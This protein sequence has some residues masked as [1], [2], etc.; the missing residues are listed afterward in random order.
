MELI[1]GQ[2]EI[3]GISVLELC[4]EY[5]TPLYVYDAAV[6]E[7][8]YNRLKNAFGTT[9]VDIHYAC[10]ALNNIN[11][12]KFI[13]NLGGSLDTVSIQEVQ[14]GL[15]AGFEPKDIMYTPNCVNIDEINRAVEFGV[16]INID[17]LSILEQ[18]GNLYKDTYPVCVRINPH[19][20]A[21]GNQKISTGHIDSKFGIS[22]YQLRHLER[23]VK[24]TGLKIIGL[25]M[26][27]G[28]DILDADVFLRGADILFE[29]ANSF[30][31]LEYLDFGSGFKVKY[32]ENDNTTNIEDLGAKISERFQEF[33]KNYGRELTLVFEPG[34]YLVSESGFLFVRTNVIKQTTATVFAGVDSGQNHLI[35]PMMY[36]AYHHITNVSNPTGIERIYT[37]VGY[38]CETDTFGWDRKL[39]EVRESDVLVL[40]NAGAYGY[41]MSSNYNSRYRPAEV[42]IHNGQAKLIRR[43]ENLDDLLSTQIE[44][45]F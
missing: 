7:R 34:K 11:I 37:V 28:S 21:G 32:H 41:S 15:K 10:K 22:I 5:G 39:N 31:E 42:L 43:R 27:T 19:I 3:G 20:M 1:N 4:K 29:A 17:N 9:K 8:Q 23:V 38:I 33:C 26:H 45:D 16:N 2:Y 30:K 18:F 25:H 14:L 35:R 12:L 6:I 44:I 36:D 24:S 13:K 40:H